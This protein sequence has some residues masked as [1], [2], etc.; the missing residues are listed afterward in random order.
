MGCAHLRAAVSSPDVWEELRAQRRLLW[1]RR[2]AQA[3]GLLGRVSKTEMIGAD[4]GQPAEIASLF[5][6]NLSMFP[7]ELM[8]AEEKRKCLGFPAEAAVLLTPTSNLQ[9]PQDK[10]PTKAHI[11]PDFY[12]PYFYFFSPRQT[13][14]FLEE[15]YLISSLNINR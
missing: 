7:E 2:R 13:V 11:Y 12:P 1:P 14:Y 8:E 6:E 4:P 3:P 15:T 5:W 9:K 10:K